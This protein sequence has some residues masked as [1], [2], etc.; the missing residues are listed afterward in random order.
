MSSIPRTV[1]RE[2]ADAWIARDRRTSED[3]R[4]ADSFTNFY[5]KG[6][7][8]KILKHICISICGGI[9]IMFVFGLIIG[10]RTEKKNCEMLAKVKDAW[11][12]FPGEA[13]SCKM[14]GR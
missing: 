2:S 8:V 11:I 13:L 10:F 6:G 5:N 1:Q 3:M 12:A 4:S 9:A 7:K 14:R